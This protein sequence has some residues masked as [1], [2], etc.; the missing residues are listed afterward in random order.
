MTRRVLS[1]QIA[2]ETNTFSRQPATLR[3]FRDRQF[4]RGGEVA[5]A[6]AG[7]NTEMGAHLAVAE[8]RGWSLVQP[9]SCF[10]TPSGPCPAADWETLKGYVAE[11]LDTG[12][13]DGVLAALHGA[14][15][16]EGEDDAEGALLALVRDRLGPDV[17]VILTLDLHANV[18]DRMAA[19]SNAVIA[20]RTY[21]HVDMGAIGR[22]AAE[23]LAGMMDRGDGPA[24][25]AVV[26][27]PPS[28][29]GADL[30]RTN[31]PNGPMPRLL[32]EAERLRVATPGVATVAI[33]AGFPWCDIEQAGPTVT[34]SGTAPDAALAAVADRLSALVWDSRDETT[35]RPVSIAEAMALARDGQGSGLPLVI[36]DFTD[37]P[38]MGSYG[39]HVR[40]LRAMIAAGLEN[41]LFAKVPDP[42]AV[43]TCFEAGEGA[44]VTLSLGSVI[45]PDLYGPPLVADA[46]VER[47]GDGAYR[48]AG[49]MFAGL[50]MS[51]GDCALVRIGGVR[52]IVS[53]R[54]LQVMDPNLVRALGVEPDTFDTLV[55]KSAQHFRAAFEP[56]ARQVVLVDSGALS[57]P[58]FRAFPFHRLRRPIHPLDPVGGGSP[59]A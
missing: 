44:S 13:Y 21:P 23:M 32:A 49:P 2:H 58:N 7:T 48:N 50:P 38:G 1:F 16:C 5:R 46:V 47:L 41:A 36:A 18:T 54:T 22:E 25:R 53:S 15:V 4:Y 34:V 10:A 40:L 31:D 55:V 19:L 37:N 59:L 24:F 28:L 52:V 9:I 26:R 39:D 6:M 20:Y 14:M 33:C 56:M 51:L 3:K 29:T 8:E 11:A 30:G 12:P 35:A 43:R 17:P 27:R 57:T 42:A 45:D